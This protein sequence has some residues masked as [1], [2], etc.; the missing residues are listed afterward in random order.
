[1]TDDLLSELDLGSARGKRKGPLEIEILRPLVEEDLP[2]LISPPPVKAPPS[3]ILSIRH[4]HH[5]L[6]QLLARGDCTQTEAALITGYSLSYISILKTDPAF[7]ELLSQYQEER[8]E[9]FVDVLERMKVLGLSTL[10][11]LQRRLEE[12]P[13]GWSRRELMEMAELM[14]VKPHQGRASAA[15][16]PAPAVSVN[17]KFVQ[18]GGATE[19]RSAVDLEYED[20]R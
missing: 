19:V 5:Q 8:K 15:G 3:S 18:A 10:D 2:L 11:E 9:I 20:V 14:L 16:A 13:E 1:M 12:M 6:A 17:V 4:S 7:A